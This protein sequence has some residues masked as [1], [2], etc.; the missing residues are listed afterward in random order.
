MNV[1]ESSQRH[2]DMSCYTISL[3]LQSGKMHIY[4]VIYTVILHGIH[5]IYRDSS[6]H[7]QSCWTTYVCST[8]APQAAGFNSVK[9]LEA[10]CAF[11]YSETHN[12]SNET[13]CINNIWQKCI[14]LQRW[15]K[16]LLRA[17]MSTLWAKWTNI[18]RII[19]PKLDSAWGAATCVCCW[20]NTTVKSWRLFWILEMLLNVVESASYALVLSVKCRVLMCAWVQPSQQKKY[21]PLTP[22][23]FLQQAWKN[24]DNVCAPNSAY[25]IW[26]SA[27]L[28]IHHSP[29]ER[30]V[31]RV[32]G[33]A[34]SS[35]QS[36]SFQVQ[37]ICMRGIE[38]LYFKA[39]SR[40]ILK[41]AHF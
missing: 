17:V 37:Y 21:N 18:P 34:L 26:S 31:G 27:S 23:L 14:Y 36:S 1:S 38:S 29:T 15:R 9:M 16:W 41:W 12:D 4:T 19:I 24:W 13:M 39:H 7:L 33:F 35:S 30:W 6:S 3:M 22:F 11:V 10:Q 40:H 28:S 2:L 5:L 20:T 25:L 32:K 8:P